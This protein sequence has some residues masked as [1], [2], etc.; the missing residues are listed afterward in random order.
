MFLLC[1]DILRFISQ[2]WLIKN[3]LNREQPFTTKINFSPNARA[4]KSPLKK[5]SRLLFV[6]ELAKPSKQLNS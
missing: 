5:F 2:N 4:R 1:S 6:L 3:W